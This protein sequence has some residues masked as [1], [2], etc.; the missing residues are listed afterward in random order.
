MRNKIYSEKRRKIHS[1]FNQVLKH[2][3]IAK[4]IHKNQLSNNLEIDPHTGIY[5]QF[6]IN[7]YLKELHP[8]TESNFGIV[9]LSVDNWCEIKNKYTLKIAHKALAAIAQELLQNIRETDLVGRYSESE[10]I[11]ILSDVTQDQAHHIANRLSLLMNHYDLKI[12]NKVIPLQTSCGASVS[13]HDS[14]SNAVLQQ[15]DQALYIAKTN[16]KACYTGTGVLS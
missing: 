15:A 12:N 5:N 9:L 16:R 8:Q 4:L 13:K 14:M 7:T 3:F 2:S 6:A 11:L 10:F 1:L